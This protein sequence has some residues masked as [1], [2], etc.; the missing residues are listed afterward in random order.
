[1]NYLK[2]S[3]NLKTHLERT[4]QLHEAGLKKQSSSVEQH[5]N[6]ANT[7]YQAAANAVES[8]PDYEYITQHAL[9]VEKMNKIQFSENKSVSSPAKQDVI[10][11]VP[12]S[13]HIKVGH[14]LSVTPEKVRKVKLIQTLDGFDCANR[15]DCFS[16]D[17]LA[18]CDYDVKKVIIYHK[19]NGK[20]EKK[21]NLNLA[22]GK[23]I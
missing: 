7:S 15:L 5:I 13:S 10:K 2:E 17:L 3:Q 6:S 8:M 11:F 18:I 22:P 14:I 12:N 21:L 16:D 1:M 20:Y 9:L 23:S 19:V 4:K